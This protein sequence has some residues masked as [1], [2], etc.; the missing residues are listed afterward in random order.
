MAGPVQPL[1]LPRERGELIVRNRSTSFQRVQRITRPHQTKP[2]GRHK[3]NA[4]GVAPSG[5]DPSPDETSMPDRN[6]SAYD[7]PTPQRTG[8]SPHR[9]HGVK[10]DGEDAW[11]AQLGRHYTRGSYRRRL[12]TRDYGRN[13]GWS[14]ARDTRRDRN[15]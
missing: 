1:N 3:E 14:D 8:I 5:H 9:S 7:I 2:V 11:N 12:Q 6:N 15:A 10:R 13:G 4:K